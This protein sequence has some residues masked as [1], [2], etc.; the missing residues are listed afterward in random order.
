MTTSIQDCAAI[1]RNQGTCMAFTY[2]IANGVQLCTGYSAWIV[3]PG[4]ILSDIGVFVNQDVLDMYGYKEDN[5]V[6]ILY[7]IVD[8]KMDQA[9]ASSTCTNKHTRLLKVDTTFKMSRLQIITDGYFV[10][11]QDLRFYVAG[12][13][14]SQNWSYDGGTDMITSDIWSPG[15]PD[16]GQ[17][18]CVML[19]PTG[20]ASVDCQQKLFSICGT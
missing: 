11:K 5:E 14:S 18:H 7:N 3:V 8:V 4:R 17:G 10:L 19:T 13:Y 9:N 1:C 12:V 16:P 2:R 6:G 15:N 20:L